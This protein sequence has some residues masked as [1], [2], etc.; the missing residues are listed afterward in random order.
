MHSKVA[1]GS[2]AQ[3]SVQD[4]CSR[5]QFITFSSVHALISQTFHYQH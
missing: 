5:K 3:W 4:S 2:S 1:K